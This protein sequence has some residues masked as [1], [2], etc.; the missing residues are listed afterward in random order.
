MC[1]GL[2]SGNQFVFPSVSQGGPSKSHLAPASPFPVPFSSS[3]LPWTGSKVNWVPEFYSRGKNWATQH[4]YWQDESHIPSS[5]L[6]SLERHKPKP[7][8]FPGAS[9]GC[10]PLRQA[11]L[12]GS[13]VWS[14]SYPKAW[15]LPLLDHHLPIWISRRERAFP[16]KVPHSFSPSPLLPISPLSWHCC[17]RNSIPNLWSLPWALPMYTPCSFSFVLALALRCTGKLISYSLVFCSTPIF[18]W[19]SCS[20]LY[21][22]HLHIISKHCLNIWVCIVVF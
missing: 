16:L 9:T 21:R 10:A 18:P 19:K 6:S 2:G 5:A 11:C 12:L 15:L 1:V 8:W 14:S 7:L 17:F 3:P 20:W 13:A 22:A 4:M